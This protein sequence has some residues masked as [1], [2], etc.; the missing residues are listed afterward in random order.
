MSRRNDRVASS[1]DHTAERRPSVLSDQ[2]RARIFGV[3]Y[4]VTFVTA[5]AAV[6]L[7]QPVLDDPAGYIATA[8]QD[9]RILFA[10]LPELLLI[11]AKAGLT[12][13]AA[14]R[15]GT[16]PRAITETVRRNVRADESP[17]AGDA[18]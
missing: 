7:F 6:A 4:L 11:I 9:N 12:V 18:G 16:R 17:R 13:R 15:G 3:L 8:G 10:A 2:Q 14:E 5:I 1:R